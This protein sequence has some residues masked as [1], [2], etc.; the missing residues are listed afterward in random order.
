MRTKLAS[1]D[2]LDLMRDRPDQPAS[3]L[4]DGLRPLA[5]D[6]RHEVTSVQRPLGRVDHLVVR[7][8][9]GVQVKPSGSA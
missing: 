5:E 3:E 8:A 9:P 2:A 1:F 4:V 6:H 7:L